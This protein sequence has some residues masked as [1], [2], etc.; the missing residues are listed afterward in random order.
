MSLK[1]NLGAGQVIL[2][3]QKLYPDEPTATRRADG[4]EKTPPAFTGP[5]G[6]DVAPVYRHLRPLPETCFEAGWVN[7]DR[8]LHPGIQEQVDLF[9]FPW[10]R[11]SNGSPWNDDTV[12]EIYCSHIIEHVPHEA[13]LADGLPGATA[14]R[15]RELVERLDGWFM[16]FYECWRILKPD[17]RVHVVAPFGLSQAGVS[18]PTHTRL[19]VP[20][21]FSYL[22]PD[23]PEAPFDYGIPF[24]FEVEGA[25]LIRFR[26]EWAIRAGELD[27]QQALKLSMSYFDVC[28]EIRITLRAVKQHADQG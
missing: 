22:K 10:V 24:K 3:A 9:R 12:D 28:D 18:D 7:V 25:P 16:F 26:E 19:I 14:A 20:G 5:E 17:G 23:N 15:Y 2:P 1:L 4:E 13:R 21:S 6:Y 11:S 8:H 27:P